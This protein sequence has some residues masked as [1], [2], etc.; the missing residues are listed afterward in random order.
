MTCSIA[1]R[2]TVP[3]A[4]ARTLILRHTSTA[5]FIFQPHVVACSITCQRS[6]RMS[7][8]RARDTAR[9]QRVALERDS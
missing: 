1:C 7:T 6:R 4:Y 5:P 9:A 3:F 8:N 2:C